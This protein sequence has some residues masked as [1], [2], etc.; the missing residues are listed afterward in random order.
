MLFRTAGRGSIPA[1]ERYEFLEW[2]EETAVTFTRPPFYEGIN[3][4][5]LASNALPSTPPFYHRNLPVHTRQRVLEETLCFLYIVYVRFSYDSFDKWRD[6]I[7]R[8]LRSKQYR[9]VNS[10]LKKRI[11]GKF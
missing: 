8:C 5:N 4:R 7:A 9:I 10:E 6:E 2:N 3:R 1:D 11:E